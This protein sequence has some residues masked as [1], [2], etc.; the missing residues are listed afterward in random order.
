MT[1]TRR[2]PKVIPPNKFHRRRSTALRWTSLEI[3]GANLVGAFRRV[4]GAVAYELWMRQPEDLVREAV[5][6]ENNVEPS[7]TL[8]LDRARDV[9]ILATN[10]DFSAA[11][12]GGG[13]VFGLE[14]IGWHF[15][16]ATALALS[17]AA[18][19]APSAHAVWFYLRQ[20]FNSF[21]GAG[22]SYVASIYSDSY[23]VTPGVEYTARASYRQIDFE[24]N[25]FV[26]M[27]IEWLDA[28]DATISFET[29]G[30]IAPD[31]DEF[32]WIEFAALVAAAPAQ[33][34]AARLRLEVYLPSQATDDLYSVFFAGASLVGS[35]S[36]IEADALFA[37]KAINARGV[38][39]DFSEWLQ[40]SGGA[41][42][43][44]V[45]DSAGNLNDWIPID[46]RYDTIIL[47]VT[48]GTYHLKSFK[49]CLSDCDDPMSEISR[50]IARE[51]D[52]LTL[53]LP[54]DSQDIVLHV[55]TE[56][57]VYPILWRGVD[58]AI[59]LGASFNLLAGTVHEFVVQDGYWHYKTP[60]T[61]AHVVT[62]VL[63]LS[64]LP[65]GTSST[66]VSAGNHSHSLAA[67]KTSHEP[68]GSDAL[69]VDAAAAT[70]SLR[71]L[72]SGSTQAA[73]GNHSHGAS[74]L[75]GGQ[76]SQV[77]RS[78]EQSVTGTT[79]TDVTDMSITLTTTGG[80]VFVLYKTVGAVNDAGV[81]GLFSLQE[82]GTEIDSMNVRS[83][84]GSINGGS[85]A[86]SAIRSP[87]SGSHTYKV[88]MSAGTG[89]YTVYDN[90][91]G[92]ATSRLTVIE[93]PH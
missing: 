58:G 13:P 46:R 28:D 57:Y 79:V 87:A 91:Q 27:R 52:R 65:V 56:S 4:A 47:T 36:T 60:S 72:G 24:A 53:V 3:V 86:M 62:G 43:L 31:L 50:N 34:A 51:G 30:N 63:A 68:S 69:T 22:L 20:G 5:R 11:I 89:G 45:T 12:A 92:R 38:V 10:A 2:A 77:S 66:Q 70:G 73:A 26:R 18:A 93:F 85:F 32:G 9:Q 23:A 42:T 48:S 90:Y 25:G 88:R 37:F 75:T 40:P 15:N 64:H 19:L 8:P 76:S 29:T 16:S 80:K 84:G 7:F 21:D 14:P 67:H 61:S 33:A 41:R 49:T 44:V 39:S 35:Y 74:G 17:D 55:N 71:T 82:D 81:D 54:I 78:T 83:L 6:V 59:D 1:L